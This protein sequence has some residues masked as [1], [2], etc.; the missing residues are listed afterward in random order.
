MYL[1]CPSCSAS[2][3]HEVCRATRKLHEFLMGLDAD[4]C[5]TVRTN[6]LSSDPLPSL[7]RVYQ[8]VVQV[9]RV[10]LAHTPSDPSLDVVS[11]FLRA[12]PRANSASYCHSRPRVREDK[13]HL[14]LNHCKKAGHEVISYFEL[15]GYPAWWEE[16]G[17]AAAIRGSTRSTRPQP[18]SLLLVMDAASF[19]PM[20]PLLPWLLLLLSGQLQL[21]LLFLSPTSGRP[22]PVYWLIQKFL[23]N[24]CSVC[25]LL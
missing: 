19:V 17:Q 14:T 11:Y 22:W 3:L 15:L 6:I 23:T 24:I 5:S 20:P 9:E 12:T 10:R 21:L 16:R 7:D 25:F 18:L 1:L 13:S 8:L 4:F 2:Q